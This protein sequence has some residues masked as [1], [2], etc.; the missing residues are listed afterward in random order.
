MDEG[1]ISPMKS[2]LERTI[3]YNRSK[4]KRFELKLSYE[5]LAFVIGFFKGTH[6]RE[7]NRPIVRNPQNLVGC[8]LPVMMAPTCA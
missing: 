1:L 2:I 5:S 7:K 6:I 3:H 4:G 8:G